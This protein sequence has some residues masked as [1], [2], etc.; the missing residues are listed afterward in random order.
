[1][2]LFVPLE[3]N[4]QFRIIPFDDGV[5][6]FPSSSL[7]VFNATSM[8]LIGRVGKEN[9]HF[10]HGFSK[11]FDIRDY[12]NVEEDLILLPIGFAKEDKEGPQIVFN[13]TFEF[14]PGQ[15]VILLLQAPS[16]PGSHRIKVNKLLD[17]SPPPPTPAETEK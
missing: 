6:A 7:T 10:P 14:V 12:Y 16:R 11:V 4:R 13:N 5:T 15:R 2:L 8:D 1:M 17:T 3:G 9:A